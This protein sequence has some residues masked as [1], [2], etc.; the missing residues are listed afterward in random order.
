[1]VVLR[2]HR[3]GALNFSI[4]CKKTFFLVLKQSQFKQ[5]QLEMSCKDECNAKYKRGC[6]QWETLLKVVHF[7]SALIFKTFNGDLQHDNYKPKN[8]TVIR[9]KSPATIGLGFFRNSITDSLCTL[10]LVYW[11]NNGG[12]KSSFGLN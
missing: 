10:L 5:E 2:G 9:S 1:M 3:L 4:G 7:T 8:K 12:R 6:K 11:K